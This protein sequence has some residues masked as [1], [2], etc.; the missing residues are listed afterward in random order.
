[1]RKKKAGTRHA[2]LLYQRFWARI[3][4]ITLVLSV[5]LVAVWAVGEFLGTEMLGPGT[6]DW[7]LL[8]ALVSLLFTVVALIAR[9]M[10]Y[11]Q[12]RS[13]HLRVVTPFF[14][15]RV[16]FRRIVT[17][18]ATS[19]LQLFPPQ[20]ASGAQ[21][22]FLDP[23]YSRTIIVV[24]MKGTPLPQ[25]ILRAFLSS[26]VISSNPPRLILVVDDWMK[27]STELDSF[28]GAWRQD[29]AQQRHR[30]KQGRPYS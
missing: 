29:L 14:P 6:R 13:D 8:G 5:V 15:L 22:R 3:W 25:S 26:Y 27:L 9:R 23:F 21:R 7:I 1:M 2:L 24:E 17:S 16:S 30:K 11:V 10:G 12:V 4:K 28:I 20:N 18:R 19:L